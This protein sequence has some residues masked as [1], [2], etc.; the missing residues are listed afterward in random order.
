MG[1]YVLSRW[2]NRMRFMI[3]V[4]LVIWDGRRKRR[5]RKKRRVE[6]GCDASDLKWVAFVVA[7]R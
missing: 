6:G 3:E 2:Q 7:P 4:E 1:S 5:K